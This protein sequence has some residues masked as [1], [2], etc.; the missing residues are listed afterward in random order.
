M[1]L[2]SAENVHRVVERDR[3]VL[4][5]HCERGDRHDEHGCVVRGGDLSMAA[6]A[7]PAPRR[8]L[9]H[10][11]VRV[12]AR[13]DVEEEGVQHDRGDHEEHLEAGLL[14]E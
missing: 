6:G 7:R 13:L 10:E 2:C 9:E 1:S 5:Q 12:L 4:D 8:A 14:L 11:E 3:E